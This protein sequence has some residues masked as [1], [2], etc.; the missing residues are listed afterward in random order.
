MSDCSEAVLLAGGAGKRLK[1]FSTFTSKHLL[2]IDNVPMIFYPLKNLQLI[3]IKKN[4][5]N[6]QSRAQISMGKVNKYV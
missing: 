4:F 3:G 2:P 5:F 6:N 1:P